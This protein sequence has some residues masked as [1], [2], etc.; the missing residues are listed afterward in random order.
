MRSHDESNL[1]IERLPTHEGVD[2]LSI[3]AYADDDD[4][5]FMSLDFKRL[6]KLTS[7]KNKLESEIYI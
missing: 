3:W 6:D 4:L 7:I 2:F 5:E 1:T